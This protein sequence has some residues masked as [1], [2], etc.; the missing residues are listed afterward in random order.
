[1]K[2]ILVIV[3]SVILVVVGGLYGFRT[4]T[5]SHS[6]FE[7][8]SFDEKVSVAYCRPFKDG[9]EIFGDLVPY[10]EVWR[11]GANEATVFKTAVPVEMEGKELP[12]GTYSLW[13]IPNE[14][15]W[16]IIFNS[17]TGQWGLNMDAKANR[18]PDLDV[19]SIERAA[20]RS[21]EVHEQ[22][23]ILFKKFKWS[24]NQVEMLLMW[25]KTLITVPITLK[26]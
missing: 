17:Q 8:A 24:E 19:L 20:I 14:E 11:T 5:K 26:E 13:T 16:E 15:S 4:W 18:N 10:G 9:R 12:P 22:F 23:T 7:I 1:M 21:D 2:K 6:P 3:V 25:D